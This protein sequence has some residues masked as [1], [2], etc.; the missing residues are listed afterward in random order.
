M[1]VAVWCNL[2]CFAANGWYLDG[3][4]VEGHPSYPLNDTGGSRS[5]EAI[6]DRNQGTGLLHK[7]S[8]SSR[9]ERMARRAGVMIIARKGHASCGGS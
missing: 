4:E 1:G 9:S 8:F 7:T 6:H 3:A 2:W 5:A